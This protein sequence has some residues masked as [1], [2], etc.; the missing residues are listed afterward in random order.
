MTV[1]ILV[2]LLAVP[3]Y[4]VAVLTQR[5]LPL[6]LA[7]VCAAV[8]GVLT[9]N[10]IYTGIDLIGVVLAFAAGNYYID[11]L[12]L[13]PSRLTAA[14]RADLGLRYFEGRELRQDQEFGLSLLIQAGSEGNLSAQ[15]FLIWLYSFNPNSPHHDEANAAIWAG[16]AASKGSSVGQFYLACHDETRPDVALDLLRVLA[17]KGDNFRTMAHLLLGSAVRAQGDLAQAYMWYWLIR[18]TATEGTERAKAVAALEELQ[19]DLS[20]RL[21]DEAKE[22][23]LS[24]YTSWDTW[25]EK[26]QEAS[27]AAADPELFNVNVW[28]QFGD[29]TEAT[30]AVVASNA[31]A[32]IEKARHDASIDSHQLLNARLTNEYEGCESDIGL[33]GDAWYSTDDDGNRDGPLFGSEEAVV[34][35]SHREHA[36]DNG[37]RIAAVLDDTEESAIEPPL[38]EKARL[39]AMSDAARRAT[40]HS[41]VTRSPISWALILKVLAAIALTWMVLSGGG[42]EGPPRVGPF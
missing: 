25:Q 24:P 2:L 3:I 34:A 30:V 31:D 18:E 12:A 22:C 26:S 35:H 1:L 42:G 29:G 39:A 17:A 32:A 13:N 6:I 36:I 8:I 11:Q 14:E 37:G 28:L 15:E 41:N 27:A 20:P 4:L 5:K 33:S 23:A 7:V 21:I 38:F 19:I 10:P 40:V 16:R 9:G